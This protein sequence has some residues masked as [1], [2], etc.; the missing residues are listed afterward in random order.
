M[1]D[2]PQSHVARCIVLLP[3]D[4]NAPPSV[5][6]SAAPTLVAVMGSEDD[7]DV[8]VGTGL[9]A[10]AK[11]PD[12]SMPDPESAPRR[13]KRRTSVSGPPPV[14][15]PRTAGFMGPVGLTAALD[16]AGHGQGLADAGATEPAPARTASSTKPGAP[17][18]NGAATKRGAAATTGTSTKTVA[19]RK[20]GTATKNGATKRGTA[21]KN[22]ASTRRAASA[23]N[24]TTAT[25]EGHYDLAAEARGTSPTGH[26]AS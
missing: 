13:R 6:T 12:L 23:R 14:T 22:G 19:S 10:G 18:K 7:V 1:K 26:A 16:V 24:G 9:L 11:R 5:L 20:N 15:A 17:A 25:T 4:P 3:P 8:P 21:T 2:Q